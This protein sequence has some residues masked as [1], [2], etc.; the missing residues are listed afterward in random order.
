MKKLGQL[1]SVC[2]L[3]MI[4]LS[5]ITVVI[6]Y[7]FNQIFIPI[8]E[9]IVYL[10]STVFMLG[11]VY[12][13]SYDK[14]VRIDIFYQNYSKTKQNKT[15]LWGTLL[16][17]IPFFVFLFYACFDY[18]LASWSRLEGSAEPGGLPFVYG[19][20]TLMLLLPISM[21]FYSLLLLKRNK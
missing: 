16:L 3:L 21:I 9:L 20:K 8:Q 7:F 4:G 14:H 1:L 6:H 11:I 5:F 17:L 18:V 13:F 15:N 12:A 19:Q 10:H 2:V